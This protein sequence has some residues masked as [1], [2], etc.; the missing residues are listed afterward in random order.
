MIFALGLHID[1]SP[2]S[3]EQTIIDS[4]FKM[5]RPSRGSQ[6]AIKREEDDIDSK[7]FKPAQ[8]VSAAK[9][10]ANS[11]PDAD[12][13][14]QASTAVKRRKG[15]AKGDEEAMPLLERTAVSSL[16]RAMYIGAHVSAAGGISSCPPA[17]KQ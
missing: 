7:E 9:R 10:K 6:K 16:N 13:N 14:V 8:S 12:N 15:K 4:A 11:E 3:S 17:C 1:T 5:P 2:E